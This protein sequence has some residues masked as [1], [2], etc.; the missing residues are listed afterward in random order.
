VAQLWVRLR[1]YSQIPNMSWERGKAKSMIWLAMRLS[2]FS[3]YYVLSDS[4]PPSD[5]MENDI[6][7]LFRGETRLALAWSLH[8]DRPLLLE[9]L[10]LHYNVKNQGNA[11]MMKMTWAKRP[12]QNTIYAMA[13]GKQWILELTWSWTNNRGH[14]LCV[15]FCDDH[16]LMRRENDIYNSACWPRN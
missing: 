12:N 10:P 1:P 11:N 13:D 3:K 2:S 9:L 16:K 8:S 4:N 15:P 6:C 5:T 14:F 7:C